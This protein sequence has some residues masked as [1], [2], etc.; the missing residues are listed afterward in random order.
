MNN[1]DGILL[2]TRQK[3][4]GGAFNSVR[5]KLNQMKKLQFS[6][7]YIILSF[8]QYFFSCGTNY[9]LRHYRV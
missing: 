2:K 6:K 1:F 3:N 7:N 5:E 9:T 8:F 4:T